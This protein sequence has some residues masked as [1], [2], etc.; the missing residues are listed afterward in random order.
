MET[1]SLSDDLTSIDFA[2]QFAQKVVLG[3]GK[4]SAKSKTGNK[5][6][7]VVPNGAIKRKDGPSESTPKSKKLKGQP[8]GIMRPTNT[9]LIRANGE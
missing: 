8:K 9:G 1:Q 7:H 5:S 6:T 4:R 2:D 3:K